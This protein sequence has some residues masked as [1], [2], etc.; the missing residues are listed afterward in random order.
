M[1]KSF[2]D[3]VEFGLSGGY[4]GLKGGLPKFDK[5]TNGIQK[6]TYYLIG[7]GMKT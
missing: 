3:E 6:S 5:F 1:I 4:K 2:L 7:A